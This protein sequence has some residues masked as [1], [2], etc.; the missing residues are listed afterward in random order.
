VVYNRM[1]QDINTTPSDKPFF[2]TLFTLSSHEPFEVPMETVIQGSD[3]QSKFLNAMHYADHS[4]GSF[5]EE[6]KKQPWWQ[7]TLVVVVADHGHRLP[8]TDSEDL[9][10]EFHIPMLWLGGA[11]AQ[12]NIVVDKLSSQIDIAPTLLS[13]LNMPYSQYRWGK[14]IFNP[15]VRPFAY[16]VFNDGF[17]LLQP[18]KQLLF[19]NVGKRVISSNSGEEDLAI[20]KSYLQMAY[21]DY[22]DK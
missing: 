18:G 17:G 10:K 19:D 12:K 4:L 6:A 8:L 22:L 5:I 14:D 3:E 11:L 2:Y 7:N 9:T 16:F 21:Q 15:T 20:G 13:Q 1:M